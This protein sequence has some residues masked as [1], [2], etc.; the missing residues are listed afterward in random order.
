MQRAPWGALEHARLNPN[1]KTRLRRSPLKGQ[2]P[3]PIE[4]DRIE[5]VHL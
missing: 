5:E 1:Q 3:Q 2:P 4:E